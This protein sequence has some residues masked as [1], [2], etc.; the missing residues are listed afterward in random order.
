MGLT[1]TRWPCRVPLRL[2]KVAGERHLIATSLAY[3]R[4]DAL[5]NAAARFDV[6]LPCSYDVRP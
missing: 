3:A 4:R 5:R 1:R 6:L 2:L